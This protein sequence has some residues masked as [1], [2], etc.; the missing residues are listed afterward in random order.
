LVPDESS[1][2]AQALVVP[3]LS[4]RASIHVLDHVAP[5]ADFVIACTKMSPWPLPGRDGLVQLLDDRR[6]RGYVAVF[7]ENGWIVLRRP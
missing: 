1:V 5:D 3:H 6:R 2:V 4:Q 7:E